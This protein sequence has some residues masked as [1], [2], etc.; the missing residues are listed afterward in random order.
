VT[1]DHDPLTL[2]YN[3]RSGAVLGSDTSSDRAR[4]EDADGTSTDRLGK[5]LKLLEGKSNGLTW[6]EV[7]VA[8]HLHHGQASGALSMLHKNGAIFALRSTRDRCHPYVHADLRS[9][10]ADEQRL[11]EPVRTRASEG[12]DAL[13]DV[14]DAVDA[15]LITPSVPNLQRLTV[16]TQRYRQ[17]QAG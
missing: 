5:V 3:G 4:R 6:R 10:W 9:Q 16:A 13:Q 1:G 15:V 11:D 7:A 17:A 8:L 2:P 12:R 14:L